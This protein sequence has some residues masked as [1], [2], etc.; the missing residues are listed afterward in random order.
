MFVF[1]CCAVCAFVYIWD[2]G[3]VLEL[4]CAMMDGFQPKF[5]G[6]GIDLRTT[7]WFYRAFEIVWTFGCAAANCM[8]R[9]NSGPR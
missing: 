7:V 6:I 4:T 9:L 3:G 8:S 1:S 2:G 5:L